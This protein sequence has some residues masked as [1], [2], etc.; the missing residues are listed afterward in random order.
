MKPYEKAIQDVIGA[1]GD[2]RDMTRDQPKLAEAVAK[3]ETGISI[4]LNLAAT[5][6]D[7]AAQRGISLHN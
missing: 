6:L 2:L 7:A 3:A 5:T 4:I 1:F